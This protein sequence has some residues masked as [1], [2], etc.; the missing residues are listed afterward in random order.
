MPRGVTTDTPVVHTPRS[1]RTR[2]IPTQVSTLTADEDRQ[3]VTFKPHLLLKFIC[4]DPTI[5][6][7]SAY[8]YAVQTISYPAKSGLWHIVV[9]D[10]KSLNSSCLLRMRLLPPPFILY[11]KSIIV[12]T[13]FKSL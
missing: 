7:D 8:R 3:S 5:S 4:G 13:Y 10:F 9:E 6:A 11:A 1:S 12:L 2:G